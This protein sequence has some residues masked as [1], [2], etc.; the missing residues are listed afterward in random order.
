MLRRLFN[1]EERFPEFF[2]R[3]FRYPMIILTKKV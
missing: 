2:V 1:L 3:H